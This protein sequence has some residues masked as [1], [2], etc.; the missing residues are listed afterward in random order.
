MRDSLRCGLPDWP[1]RRWAE[2]VNTGHHMG[3]LRV[4]NETGE[5]NPDNPGEWTTDGCPGSWYRSPWTLSIAP[6]ERMLTDSGFS[7]N[8]HLSR[9]DDRLLLDAVAYL[10]TQRVRARNHYDRLRAEHQRRKYG[11]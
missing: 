2:P 4:L 7:E 10:E 6:Y 8:M 3:R 5:R 1:E 9:S 11:S